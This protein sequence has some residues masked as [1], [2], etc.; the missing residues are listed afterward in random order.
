MKVS[1]AL[2]GGAARGIAHI[3]VLKAVEELG[4]EVFALSGSSAGAVVSVFYASGYSP[5]EML[6][7]VKS[8]RWISVLRPTLPRR[9]II[10]W[11]R[12]EKF[13]RSLLG[14]EKL[15][16]L[17]KKVF[18]CATDLLRAKPIYFEKGDIVPVLLGSCAIPG[19]FEPV[20]YEE[21]LLADGGLMNNLPVEPLLSLE[22]LK[23]GVDVNPVGEVSE[24]RS[25][26]GVV[27]RSF[28][29]AVRSNVGARKELCDAVVEPDLL[30]FSP[31]DVGKAEDIF[32]AGYEE[33]MRVLSGLL[34]K[35]S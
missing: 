16:E 22:G 12:A 33:G 1:L 6:R 29:L 28:F 30:R 18:V 13:L 9:G 17:R 27:V 24:I 32:R 23:V 5:D 7:I 2:S 8:I 14:A 26:I 34:E 15:E 4:L 21:Y 19:V 35:L 10:S 3:G 11:K 25:I 20:R 31:L